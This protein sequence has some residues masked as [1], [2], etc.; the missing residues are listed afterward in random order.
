[1][2]GLSSLLWTTR[3]S[4]FQSY[5]PQFCKYSP[6]SE[7]ELPLPEESSS[8]SVILLSPKSMLFFARKSTHKMYFKNTLKELVS[9]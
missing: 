1:M 8:A 5:L 6:V 3:L 7:R 2:I 4:G 9:I